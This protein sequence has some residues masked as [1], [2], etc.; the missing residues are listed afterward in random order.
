MLEVIDYCILQV[1][2][3]YQHLN[4]SGYCCWMAANHLK[5]SESLYNKITQGIHGCKV[6]LACATNHY[7]CDDVC[8]R[9]IAMAEA[10]GRPIVPLVF[11][12][13][14]WPQSGDFQQKLK[15][16]KYLHVRL[17]SGGLVD[18]N[19]EN[20]KRLKQRL[21]EYKADDS[22]NNE[23]R[24]EAQPDMIT[25][26]K[27]PEGKKNLL[28]RRHNSLDSSKLQAS[29]SLLEYKTKNSGDE[30]KRYSH[31]M[32]IGHELIF[33][34]GGLP[35][36]VEVDKEGYTLKSARSKSCTIL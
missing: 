34:T 25:V 32:S 30:G 24:L 4:E 33:K 13:T 22:V 2:A 14:E 36:G 10:L 7:Y 35:S 28:D 12:K 19:S 5:G 21:D 3:L 15:K 27:S 11:G 8:K 16:Y 17:N 1:E 20:F 6:V 18:V 23:D 31:Q 29:S 9:D 26:L